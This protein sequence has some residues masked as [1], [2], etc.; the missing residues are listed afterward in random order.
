MSPIHTLNF[1]GFVGGA[2]LLEEPLVEWLR[3][4]CGHRLVEVH[5]AALQLTVQRELRSA[6]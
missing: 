1:R 5:F 2:Q 6:K 4:L 3:L